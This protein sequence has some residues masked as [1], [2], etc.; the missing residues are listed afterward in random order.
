MLTAHD[1]DRAGAGLTYVYPVLSRRAGGVSLGINLNVNHAC[2]WRCIYCQ[3]PGLKRGGPPPLDLDRLASELRGMLDA[4][5]NDDFLAREA[6]EGMR[7]LRDIAL[8]GDGE[9]TSAD[10]FDAAIAR[11]GAVLDE[12]HRP[13][14]LKLVLIS[15][16]SLTHKTAVQDGLRRL[17]KLGGEVWFKI[18]R[19]TTAGILAIN[20]THTDPARVRRN[21]AACC[22]AC[23]TRIQTCMFALDGAPP[24][25]DEIAAYLELLADARRF[26]VPPR[27]VLLYG[28][29]RPS[30]QPEAP[31]L[32]ALPAAW[33]AA[34]AERIGALGYPVQVNA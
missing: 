26:A 12:F 14:P 18:D 10:E 24:A 13:D 19:A 8:S 1:H 33:L 30:L 16:G 5:L 23:P 31:R 25:E 7:V 22:A 27:G 2:N 21:L 32:S 3:V 9:P 15:N 28:L 20:D 34:L 6:P 29:A 4:I 17:A 11:I